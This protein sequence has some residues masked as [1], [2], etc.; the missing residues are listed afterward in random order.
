M[1]I[2]PRFAFAL[3][4]AATSSLAARAAVINEIRIDDN[5]TD[6]DEYF[7]LYGPA[8]EDLSALTYIV[9]GDGAG[10]SGVVET[11]ISLSGMS[12]QSDGFFLAANSTLGTDVPNGVG[13]TIDL[14]L[15]SNT[16]EN[17]D[18]VTHLLVSGFTGASGDDL[19]TDDDGTL[20]SMPWG[21]I[22]DSVS[23]LEEVGAG[24]LVYSS[25]TVGPDGTFVPGHV[26]R[27]PDGSGDW[28]IGPFVSQFDTPG[29]ANIPEPN[30]VALLISCLGILSVRRR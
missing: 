16:F 23:L 28:N 18:N 14:T 2:V 12:I 3:L 26:Y 17:S 29:Y 10:G 11:V 21:S 13:K 4:L 27:L 15:N 6:T 9:I 19:D 24:D 30:S 25:T 5:S 8:N 20:D 7:E 1:K 22:V